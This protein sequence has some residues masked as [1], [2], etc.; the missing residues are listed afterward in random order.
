MVMEKK[1]MNPVPKGHVP[2][3][4]G[5]Y[6]VKDGDSWGI[7]ASQY[8][9]NTWDLIY[10]NFLTKNYAEVNWYL[11]H[12]VGCLK[13]TVDGKNWMFSS[14]ANPGIIYIPIKQKTVMSNIILGIH[15]NVAGK[16]KEFSAG[17]T[18]L[19]IT[20]NGKT[21]FYGLWPDAHPHTVDNGDAS[22]I[23]VG[24]EASA[25]AVASRYYKLI[26]AQAIHFD[27]LLKANVHWF[28]T[29]NCS[30]W[31]S[32]VVQ[33]ILGEDVDADDYFG[34]ETPRELGRNILR[35][36]KKDPTSIHAAKCLKRNPATSLLTRT[37]SR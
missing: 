35:L 15:S 25:T 21:T 30:F 3:N 2:L 1:P 4:S 36:E 28:Y 11:H 31:V 6:K 14:T 7:I 9:M 22:D 32:N 26:G 10:M 13:L 18:W 19:T 12:Y 20:Q 37:S 29:H 5:H 8:G 27:T 17:H 23:R 33:E 24:L 16:D 34:I